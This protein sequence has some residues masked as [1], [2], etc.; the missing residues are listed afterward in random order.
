MDHIENYNEGIIA[1]T[2]CSNGLIAKTLIT[3]NDEEKAL[4]HVSRLNE[5]FYDRLFLELQPHSLYDV[6]KHGKEVNQQKKH[7][8]DQDQKEKRKEEEEE[9]NQK[10][11]NMIDL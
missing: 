10:L 8:L 9:E 7:H 4:C 5:I 11:L 1:L 2:A 6:N 3:D